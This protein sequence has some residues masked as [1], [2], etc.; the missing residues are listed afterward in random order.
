MATAVNYWCSKN[1]FI[2]LSLLS[3]PFFIIFGHDLYQIE[4]HSDSHTMIPH[5]Y[6]ISV[7]HLQRLSD[8]TRSNYTAAVDTVFLPT[9]RDY[10]AALFNFT[11]FN[12]NNYLDTD[13]IIP[14]IIHQIW[15]THMVPGMFINWIKSIVKLHPEWEYWFWTMAD[16]KCLVRKKYQKYLNTFIHYP[17][18]IYRSDAF[19]YFA[20]YEYGGVYMDLDV[21]ALKPLDFW[22]YAFPA[23]ISFENFEHAYLMYNLKKPNLMNTILASK[24]H[25]PFFTVLHEGL[26]STANKKDLLK[27]TG[28][29]FLNSMYNK[30]LQM[31]VSRQQ[32]NQVMTIHPKYWLPRYGPAI[33]AR[34][35]CQKKFQTLTPHGKAVCNELKKINYANTIKP[36]SFLNHQW[37]HVNLWSPG[38]KRVDLH[39][40]SSIVPNVKLV[41]TF[42]KC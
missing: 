22:T 31:N 14:H 26:L 39:N 11:N 41:S 21:E 33:G 13:P 8:S 6:K 5:N 9:S 15:D 36:D 18:N 24:K 25:H 42:L 1:K 7:D 37:L 34:Y 38:R 35:L 27:A 20:L 10:G 30:Y 2:G 23:V 19:R 3:I 28:P 29:F 32:E 16:A 40:I 17:V 4:Y 12:R